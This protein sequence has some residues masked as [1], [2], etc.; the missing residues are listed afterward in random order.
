MGTVLGVDGPYEACYTN[1][2]PDEC[3]SERPID[4]LQRP[5]HCVFVVVMGQTGSH[6]IQLT[7][8]SQLHTTQEQQYFFF[9]GL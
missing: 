9:G 7:S 5:L 1:K 2:Q 4:L 8:A 6:T 3:D